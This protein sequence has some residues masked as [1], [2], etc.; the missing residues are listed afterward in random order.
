MIG[1]LAAGVLTACQFGQFNEQETETQ[2]PE[3]DL[4]PVMEEVVVHSPVE[5]PLAPFCQ[6]LELSSTTVG[7]DNMRHV[8]VSV[9]TLWREPGQGRTMDEPGMVVPAQPAMWTQTMTIPDK[10]WLVGKT[11]T[12]VQYGQPVII[13]EHRGEWVKVAVPDQY[14]PAHEAGYPGWMPAVQLSDSAELRNYSHCPF[15]VVKG[16]TASLYEQPEIG[17]PLLEISFNTRLPVLQVD[18]DWVE[19]ATPDGQRAWLAADTV[20]V[21]ETAG[22]MPRPTG[23]ELVALAEQFLDL[24]YLWGGVSAYG[25][26]CSGFTYSLYRHYGIDIPR[27]S[28][29]QAV[30][31]EAVPTD[32]L[33][34]G[35]LL[36]FAYDQGRGKV[37]HVAMY[38]GEGMMI[39]SPRTERSVEIIPLS[40]PAYEREFA[41]A[42]RFLH[43]DTDNGQ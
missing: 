43:T 29:D 26:D 24:P 30:L 42:R 21:Y 13:L 5:P 35:D 37:H 22:N 20:V 40:T 19:A 7:E 4:L 18:G 9:A 34:R 17:D 3:V 27:D 38:A 15:L 8:Q 12:Q 11:E 32:E 14:T 6:P 41:G 25:F 23:D 10:L 28:K 33:Q 2:R 1:L 31:G 39:H 16:K 36:F